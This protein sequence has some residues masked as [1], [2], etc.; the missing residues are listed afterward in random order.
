MFFVVY[1]EKIAF[2]EGDIKIEAT[3]NGRMLQSENVLSMVTKLTFWD[4]G[5][6]HLEG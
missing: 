3:I 4:V 1:V 2:A 6:S 5:I